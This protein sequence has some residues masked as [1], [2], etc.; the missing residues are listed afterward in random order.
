MFRIVLSLITLVLFS[1]STFTHAQEDANQPTESTGNLRTLVCTDNFSPARVVMNIGEPERQIAEE[2]VFSFSGTINNSNPHLIVSDSLYARV[3]R[4]ENTGVQHLIQTRV[5]NEDFE[6]PANGS[7]DFTDTWSLPSNLAGGSYFIEYALVPF[8]TEALVTANSPFFAIINESQPASLVPDSVTIN[9]TPLAEFDQSTL[10]QGTTAVVSA[11]ITNNTAEEKIVPIQW[12]LYEGLLPSEESGI[13]EDTEIASI[14]A[15]ATIEVFYEFSVPTNQQFLITSVLNDFESQSTLE[16]PVIR[17][18]AQPMI[19]AAGLTPT[20]ISIGETVELYYCIGSVTD[21]IAGHSFTF[22]VNTDAGTTVT[23]HTFDSP[24]ITAP[25]MFTFTEPATSL[26]L[27]GQVF[28]GSTILV[29][30][31]EITYQQSIS[32]TGISEDE[33]LSSG[34]D[35]TLLLGIG[36]IIILIVIISL[37]YWFLRTKSLDI[38]R[39]DYS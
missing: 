22:T 17:Q 14:P 18:V 5:I 1:S 11:R 34:P 31:G 23:E 36:I 7:F 37:I 4:I 8:R 9:G 28:R 6:I 35:L 19:V 32:A 21:K 3:F 39:I 2:A 38:N 12:R 27:I 16:I 20:D 24:P 30:S 13:D 25:H 26:N 10:G 33:R 15:D 29:D